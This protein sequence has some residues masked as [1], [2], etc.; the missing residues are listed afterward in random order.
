LI[1][2]KTEDM[3]ALN[4]FLFGVPLLP[5]GPPFSPFA[6]TP[7]PPLSSLNSSS[8][9]AKRFGVLALVHSGGRFAFGFASVLSAG[10]ECED[11]EE[12]E[13]VGGVVVTGKEKEKGGSP[14]TTNGGT[15]GKTNGAPN[16]KTFKA[17]MSS[18]F[19]KIK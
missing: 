19:R 1:F 17:I 7:P 9:D 10:F 18:V 16:K 12:E 11:D 15:N 14:T 2:R 4:V 8:Y 3:I 6:F 5:P 13:G